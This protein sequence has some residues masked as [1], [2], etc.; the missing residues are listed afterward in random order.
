[1]ILRMTRIYVLIILP[2]LAAIVL[3]S[4]NLDDTVDF[5]KLATGESFVALDVS[6]ASLA[7]FAVIPEFY[8]G[9]PQLVP[10]PIAVG[11]SYRQMFFPASVQLHD[12]RENASSHR[13]QIQREGTSL[14][15]VSYR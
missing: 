2:I 15:Q 5:N 3:S 7:A 10:S 9:N 8:I 13:F 14:V 6:N 11:S 12:S 1:M 4:C